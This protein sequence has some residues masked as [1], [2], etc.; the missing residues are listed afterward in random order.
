MR[1]ISLTDEELKFDKIRSIYKQLKKG[2]TV[3]TG[4]VKKYA[5]NLEY[6]TLLFEAL[7]KY[8][9]T[10]LFPKPLLTIEKASES[11][12]ANWLNMHDDFDSLPTKI[13]YQNTFKLADDRVILVFKF[14][15]YEPHQYANRDWMIGYVGYKTADVALYTEPDF[16]LSSFKDEFIPKN[17]LEKQ[18]QP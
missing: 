17:E 3:D 6:R 4:K 15:V 13:I 16:I 10:D 14:N 11:Y 1:K 12:L 9:A 2:T 18:T 7:K 8:D 5:G